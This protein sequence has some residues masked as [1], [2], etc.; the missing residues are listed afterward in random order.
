MRLTAF[1]HIPLA[2]ALV[3]LAACNSGSQQPNDETA[4]GQPAASATTAAETAASPESAATASPAASPASAAAAGLSAYVGKYPSDKVDGVDWNHNPVVLAGI[5]KT[6]TDPAARKAIL[7]VSGPASPITLYQ[8]KV[9]SWACE[10]HNCGDHQWT[11]MVDP[12]SGATNV[13]Y[14]NAAKLPGKSRWFM[15]DGTVEQRDGN[16]SVE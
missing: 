16:C 7:E 9:A 5:N 10:V 14:H 3:A 4:T 13:C 15:A 6:V 8:G 2:C 12:K 1:R 11:V